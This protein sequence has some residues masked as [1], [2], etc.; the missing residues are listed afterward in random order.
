MLP[1]KDKTFFVIGKV[2]KRAETQEDG[3]CFGTSGGRNVLRNVSNSP[4]TCEYLFLSEKH[5]K[6][7]VCFI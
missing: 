5:N 1:V 2:T 6:V 7:I 3:K 4:N